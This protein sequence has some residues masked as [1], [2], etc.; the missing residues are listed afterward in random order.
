ML[1]EG[2][3]SLTGSARPLFAPWI[4]VDPGWMVA[5][6]AIGCVAGNIICVHNVVAASAGLCVSSAVLD[7]YT[8]L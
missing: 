5:L 3:A 1:A 7:M 8:C 4:G 2:V 6:Q